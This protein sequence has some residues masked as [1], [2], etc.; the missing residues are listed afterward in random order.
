[1]KRVLMRAAAFLALLLVSC[2]AVPPSGRVEPT[3][4]VP[5]ERPVEFIILQMNDIYE[6]TP[7]SGGK[8]GGLARVATIRKQLLAENPNTLTVLAGDLLSPSA[9][10]A[11]RVDGE[12][13]QGRQMIAAMNA[14]GLDYS[15]FG[16]HEFD[17]TER[18][19]LERLRES[20][21]TWISSNVLDKRHM[22]FPG[23]PRNKVVEIRSGDGR[24]VRLGFFGL[25]LDENRTDYVSYTNYLEEARIQAK[26]LRGRVDVLVALTHLEASQDIALAEADLGIDL[27]LGGHDHENMQFWRGARFVPVFK[28]DAN[29]RTV[30]VHRLSYY[31]ESRRLSVR[32]VLRRVTGEIRE[33]SVTSAVIRL[34]LE[35]IF[36]AFRAEGWEPEQVVATVPV[37][38]D[39]RDSSVRR[40][41]TAL[42]KSIAE[43]I[44]AEVPGAD[45]AMF[46]G[47]SIRLDDVLPAGR[48]TELDLFRVLPFRGRICG[49]DIEG[50]LLRKVL[51]QGKAN[52]GQ[53]GFLQ[54][55]RVTWGGTEWRVNDKP[56]VARQTYRVATTDFLLSGKE[57]GLEF[58]TE[59]APGV[60]ASC[61]RN[62]DVR[63]ALKTYLEK[64]YGGR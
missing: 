35:R 34:W 18:A 32:S 28:A 56:L 46:N 21:F 54:T 11:A 27:I 16:N 1:M 52:H 44:L 53:G 63:S 26:D 60:R 10:S 61:Q 51:D 48:L 29:A 19:F 43:A 7:L 30:Y 9:L 58:L 24:R 5:E 45:L 62:S 25:T 55:A 3:G 17:L 8:E 41:S 64:T 42:T 50:A 38:W 49:A 15:T 59:N 13:L 14:L 33:D 40:F 22:S 12:R 47:G 39:G 4:R 36:A 23:V 37:D 2:A 6:M 20:R 57:Q 31:P